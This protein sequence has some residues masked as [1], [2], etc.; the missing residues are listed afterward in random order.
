MENLENY[1]KFILKNYNIQSFIIYN[2]Y[3]YPDYKY[4]NMEAFLAV[5]HC[6]NNK[7]NTELKK[8]R[9]IDFLKIENLNKSCQIL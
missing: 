2:D 1:C 8:Y 4:T 5:E 9:L 6:E 7:N 3:A